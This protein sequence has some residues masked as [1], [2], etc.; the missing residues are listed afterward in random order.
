MS[1]F[2]PNEKRTKATEFADAFLQCVKPLVDQADSMAGFWMTNP[3]YDAYRVGYGDAVRAM[4]DAVI[5]A[6]EGTAY[7]EAIRAGEM[8]KFRTDKR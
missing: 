6:A 7:A 1:R 5:R 3:E 8:K 4:R 2:P